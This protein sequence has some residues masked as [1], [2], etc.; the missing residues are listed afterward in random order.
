MDRE[1]AMGD[2]IVA[3]FFDRLTLE[4]DLRQLLNVKIIR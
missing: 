2:I 3:L 4:R 1:R